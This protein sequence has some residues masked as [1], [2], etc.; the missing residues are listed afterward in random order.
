MRSAF[1]S[2]S[3]SDD[4]YV[5]EMKS[6]LRAVGFDDVFTDKRRDELGDAK[7]ALKEAWLG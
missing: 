7:A 3:T 1:V 2:H 6:F 4:P 5:A